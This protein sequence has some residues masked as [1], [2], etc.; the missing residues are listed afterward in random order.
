MT[1]DIF[2]TVGGFEKGRWVEET[3][4]CN[5]LLLAWV[6]IFLGIMKQTATSLKDTSGNT[7]TRNVGVT[8]LALNAGAAAN[9]FGVMVG[10]GSTA[11]S[12][13]DFK[14]DTLITHGTGAT[15]VAYGAVTVS[16]PA[17]S[18]TTRYFT[19]ART[20]TGNASAVVTVNEIGLYCKFDSV[21]YYCIDRT[22]S[23]FT[24]PIATAKTVTYTIG[25]TV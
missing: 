23:T 19:I 17:T 15:Q 22:L 20:F 4:R 1:L 18:G 21:Y 6:D 25:V 8:S 5:S 3:R 2:L 10:T 13:S 11:V 24:I 12:I 16:S 9:L 7:T 14:L